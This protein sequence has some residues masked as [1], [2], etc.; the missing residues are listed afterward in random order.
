MAVKIKK[1]GAG[2]ETLSELFD[3]LDKSQS[4]GGRVNLYRGHS[5][6]THGL[7]PSLFRQKEYRRNERNI[8]RELIAI[9][10]NEFRD[11]KTTFEQLVRMQHY[12]LPTRLLDLTY[13]PL[14][15]LYF[16]CWKDLD[17]D[18]EFIRLTV[19]AR[20]VRHFDSDTVSCIANLSNLSGRERD[21]IR[22]FATSTALRRSEVGN[23]E[24]I[25]RNPMTARSPPWAGSRKPANVEAASGMR[26][27][28][29][30]RAG[31]FS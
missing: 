9:Q 20:K 21:K 18:G 5:D 12:G 11:D 1:A 13:N 24:R 27:L 16:A 15:A 2:I 26:N 3:R 6:K 23:R 14:V 25:I 30:P 8:L 19:P 31:P 7:I 4:D 22:S 28:G 29:P 10:P 17:E